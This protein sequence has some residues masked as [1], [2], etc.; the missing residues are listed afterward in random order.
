[1]HPCTLNPS[2]RTNSR[3]TKKY[4]CNT[5]LQLYFA[6]PSI[7]SSSVNTVKKY[8]LTS[9]QYQLKCE[10]WNLVWNLNL[11]FFFLWL[12][13]SWYLS[14]ILAIISPSLQ[15]DRFPHKMQT[16]SR[17][18]FIS[19]NGCSEGNF[20]SWLPVCIFLIKSFRCTSHLW[21]QEKRR[22]GETTFFFQFKLIARSFSGGCEL[23]LRTC[24]Y[25]YHI[26]IFARLFVHI[27]I[28]R[29]VH[30]FNGQSQLRN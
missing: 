14:Y 17:R 13:H 12:F 20:T 6:L 21:G 29:P 27:C 24:G 11:Y 25:Y 16:I 1:M 7:L 4:I 8:S 19:W 22:A 2:Q 23:A 15:W 26:H 3:K 30:I 5:S 28:R 10:L 18:I 9:C